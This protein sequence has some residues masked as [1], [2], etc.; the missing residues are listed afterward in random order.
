MSFF[1]EDGLPLSQ[2][3]ILENLDSASEFGLLPHQAYVQLKVYF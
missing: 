3:Q 2:D 1:G